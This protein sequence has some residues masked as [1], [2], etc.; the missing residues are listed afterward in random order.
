MKIMVAMSGGID[1]SVAALMLKNSGQEIV[2]GTLILRENETAE[3]K[4]CGTDR[5][6]ADAK[7]V[8]D[9]LGI[10][11]H[12]FDARK[13]FSEKVID[14]FVGIYKSGET[15]NPCV[16]CNNFV[17]FPEM[18]KN[19]EALGCT[20]IAT[21]HYAKVEYDEKSGRYLLL[22]AGFSAKDQTYV[23]YGLT[24]DILSRLILPLGSIADK[25]A[26]R[27][28][29]VEAGFS[30]ADRPDSQDICFIPDGD[31]A[32]F[33]ER[34]T[35]ETEIQCDFVTPEGKRVKAEWGISRYTVGQRKGLGIA[36]GRPIYV[37]DKSAESNT[38][39][40][41]DEKEL[42]GTT[43]IIRNCNFI[44]FESLT[45]PLRVTAKTRYSQK[46]LKA[47]ITPLENGEVELKFDTPQRAMTAGQSAVFYQ[48]DMVVGGGIIDRVIN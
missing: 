16:L 5:D 37:I 45:E 28:K 38:V 30:N 6:V 14:R 32:A 13:E 42:F 46:E 4:H 21:G 11:Y 29:A 9:R 20:H 36:L 34:Y 26:A 8:C 12:T 18:I 35:G 25:E 15:P 3:G 40:L 44:P 10:E 48:G 31:H 22:R 1:S 33:I 27:N 23:L 24:Q 39:T 47:T 43:A 41:G 19:A 2:G 7:A 17:K